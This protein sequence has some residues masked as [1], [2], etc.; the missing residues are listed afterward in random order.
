MKREKGKEN[1]EERKGRKEQKMKLI[2]M[3]I[4]LALISAALHAQN[5][6]SVQSAQ[7]A[8]AQ[9]GAG[10]MQALLQTAAVSYGQAAR[11]VLEA[12]GAYN[13]GNPQDAARFAAEKKWLPAKADADGAV[14]LE[15]LSLLIMKAFG[16]KGGPMYTL[17]GGAHYSYRMLVYKDIIQGRTDPHMKVSGETMLFIVNRLLF[18]LEDNPWELPSKEEA[19]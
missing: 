6:Q 17:F 7:S 15:G 18:S 16:L 9:S 3:T 11:F 2:K 14:S 8:S 1:S 5:A 12:A 19:K 13:T 4:L 10:E